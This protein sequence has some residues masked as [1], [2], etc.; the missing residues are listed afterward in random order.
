MQY[1]PSNN[2]KATHKNSCLMQKS[3]YLG[4]DT[5]SKENSIQNGGFMHHKNIKLTIRKQ[6]K[7]KFPNWR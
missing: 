2:K 4:V 3:L 1:N 5:P 7:N 6:L